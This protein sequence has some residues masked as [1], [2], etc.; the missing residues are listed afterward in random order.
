MHAETPSVAVLLFLNTSGRTTRGSI[1]LV[2]RRQRRSD[3]AIRLK[4][5]FLYASQGCF[6][7]LRFCGPRSA[8]W[9]SRARLRR[10]LGLRP[11]VQAQLQ[12][13]AVTQDVGAFVAAHGRNLEGLQVATLLHRAAG[14]RHTG[15]TVQF[16][17][18]QA[19]GVAE[20]A[21]PR[22]LSQI[23]HALALLQEKPAQRVLAELGRKLPRCR[24]RDIS[25]TLV[26]A[27]KLRFAP[28]MLLVVEACR[29]LPK[30]LNDDYPEPAALASCVHALSQLRFCSSPELQ[31]Q[32]C[33]GA[34]RHLANT[35]DCWEEQE[36]SML[37]YGLARLK[38]RN[39]RLLDEINHQ[40]LQSSWAWRPQAL[41]NGLYAL[42]LLS[43]PGPASELSVALSPQL[44][45]ALDRHVGAAAFALGVLGQRSALYSLAGRTA[46]RKLGPPQ[47]SM[48]T[49]ALARARVAHTRALLAAA[50]T[51]VHR[52]DTQ[53][54]A[55]IVYAFAMI[56][57]VPPVS[58]LHQVLADGRL[59]NYTD[60]G[61]ANLCNGLSCFHRH[62]CAWQVFGMA[63]SRE[64]SR[65]LGA[66]AISGLCAVTV[67][68]CL[69]QVSPRA[70]RASLLAQ[71]RA[72]GLAPGCSGYSTFSCTPEPVQREDGRDLP[73][74]GPQQCSRGPEPLLQESAQWSCGSLV[75]LAHALALLHRGRSALP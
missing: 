75:G 33:A 6:R 13:Q 24:P 3:G 69:A 70:V 11:A 59:P 34:A 1:C 23:F 74:A 36:T 55:N 67:V 61:L 2:E 5:V 26:A 63:V 31:A 47:R 43:T 49:Y 40:V 56:Q 20:F 18:D 14:L 16:L 44:V 32:L 51:E 28:S 30:C 15:D 50:H 17:R 64:L 57:F 25:S 22:Q 38:W 48:V 71:L 12:S 9:W 35:R 52:F 19:E 10:P 45:C 66:S 60:Q 8:M 65:R 73:E 39:S 42:S 41:A 54:I 58:F 4:Q 72:S 21:S 29:Q 62:E 46:S 53:H 27:A 37:L 7:A 68:Q